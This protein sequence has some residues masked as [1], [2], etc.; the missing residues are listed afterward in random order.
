MRAIAAL[1]VLLF[2]TGMIGGI[3]RAG[4]A[5]PYVSHLNSGVTLFFVIS[6]FLL[7]RPFVAARLAG[8]TPVRP[9][10]YLTRRALR[11]LPAYWIALTGLTVVFHL[12]GVFTGD[13]WRYYG[14][15]QIYDPR[16]IDQGMGVAWT[17]CIEATFYLSLPVVDLLVTRLAAVIP[18][19]RADVIALA[20][21]SSLS[22]IFM[23]AVHAGGGEG[24]A[25]LNL[26][27]TFDW[28][29]LG[30]AVAVLSVVRP[31]F[32]F[33][34][35]PVYWAL[36]A[37]AF[38]AVTRLDEI[39]D[40]TRLY[41]PLQHVGY[42]LV[43]VLLFLP[44]AANSSG[45]IGRILSTRVLAWTGLISYSI[46][47]L[48]ATMIA[49]LRDR[50]AG[51]LLPWNSWISLTVVTLAVVLPMAATS[52]YLVEARAPRLIRSAAGR[53]PGRALAGPRKSTPR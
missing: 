20:A 3:D 37:V 33:W 45:P 24:W 1:S 7:Y 34:S 18:A 31:D 26:L 42:G 51:S 41:Y 29:A 14:L 44:A 6:G 39:Q 23:G 12:P 9:G 53:V 38:V 50:S 13:W 25:T 35:P 30:M 47:L 17:L 5:G 48:H 40:E 21:L 46:Y 19:R 10:P 16:T 15:V 2:H 49:A 22:V 8:G 52:Y 27:G 32:R 11:I 4:A 36:A 28:F 43:A